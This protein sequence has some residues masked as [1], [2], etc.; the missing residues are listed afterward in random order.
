[1]QRFFFRNLLFLIFVNLLIKPLWIFGIDR[2]VQNAVGS[3]SYGVY[4]I[5]TN[6]SLLTQILLDLG[7]SHY[8]NRL[9]AQKSTCS[10][11]SSLIF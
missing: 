9:I 10:P 11:A 4:F 3:E 2:S 8:N 7:I 6:L 1:M 5:I